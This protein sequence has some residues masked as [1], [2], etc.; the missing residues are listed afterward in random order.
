MCA[1]MCIGMFA[2]C[3]YDVCKFVCAEWYK[4]LCKDVCNDC[5]RICIGIC[6]L[7]CVGLFVL[8]VYGCA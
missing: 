7:M 3:V 5:L 6:V 4:N 1:R 2:I 8:I